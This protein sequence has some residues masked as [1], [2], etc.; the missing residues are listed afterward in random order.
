[1]GDVT[2]G[3]SVFLPP[4]LGGGKVLQVPRNVQTSN[5]T[6]VYDT[7]KRYDVI[8]L[9][10]LWAI[11]I[12]LH[13]VFFGYPLWRAVFDIFPS[14][15][16]TSRVFR[17]GSPS[18]SACSINGINTLFIRCLFLLRNFLS[19]RSIRCVFILSPFVLVLSVLS[20]VS[21]GTSS[22]ISDG[23]WLA[24]VAYCAA[25]F[26]I[27]GSWFVDSTNGAD[28]ALDGWATHSD[29]IARRGDVKPGEFGGR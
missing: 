7:T 29:I 17:V 14:V 25:F 20:Y 8:D 2:F 1:M 5:R 21:M 15:V 18:F 6:T 23:A 22:H 4:V 9:H 19:V 27:L 3:N 13:K 26:V 11:G 16:Q 12:D 10:S 24:L 28:F